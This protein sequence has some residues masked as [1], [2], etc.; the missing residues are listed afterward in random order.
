MKKLSIKSAAVVFALFSISFF[1][2]NNS[3]TDSNKPEVVSINNCL[4]DCAAK[5]KLCWDEFDKCKGKA[6]AEEQT[7]LNICSHVPP[8]NKWECKGNA[9]SAYRDKV[10]QCERNL[11]TC[12]AQLTKCRAACNQL[13]KQP[14]TQ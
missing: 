9:I 5:E 1:S 4:L 10:E 13:V 14:D 11:R 12:L 6:A 7:A 2:C 3:K 8:A